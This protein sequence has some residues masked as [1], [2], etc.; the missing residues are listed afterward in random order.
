MFLDKDKTMDNVQQHQIYNNVPLLQ[1]FKYDLC[2]N[3]LVSN[4]VVQ[5][6]R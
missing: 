1:T 6:H 2:E 5:D 3:L 4:Y